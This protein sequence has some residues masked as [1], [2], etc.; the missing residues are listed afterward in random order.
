MDEALSG[1]APDAVLGAES[2]RDTDPEIGRDSVFWPN[3]LAYDGDYLW[4]GEFKF[5]GR[6]LRFSP[7]PSDHTA[8]L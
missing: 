3:R 7:G 5:S 4:V 1:A 6:L 2:L 8:G